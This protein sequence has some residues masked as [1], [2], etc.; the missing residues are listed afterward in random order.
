MSAS[1]HNNQTLIL[2]LNDGL[3]PTSVDLNLNSQ[4]DRQ[5]G[6]ERRC[7]QLVMIH[8]VEKQHFLES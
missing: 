1:A 2:L 3:I 5:I 7:C 6:E 8:M 4:I